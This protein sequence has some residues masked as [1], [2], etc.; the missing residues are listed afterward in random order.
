MS[1]WRFEN[2]IPQVGKTTF[3]APSAVVWGDV[4]IGE[5]C[6]VGHGAVIRGDYG[7]IVIGDGC[8]IQDLVMIHARPDDVVRIGNNA[9][10]GH[11]ALLHNCTI[12]DNAVV[13]MGAIVSDFAILKDWAV[14]AEGA[15]AKNGSVLESGQIAIG[16][17]AAV[18]GSIHDKPKAKEELERFK[19]K[20]QEMA[21]RHLADNAFEEIVN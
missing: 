6:Y 10:I 13:G 14:L 12:E 3:V 11:R 4:T 5:G 9:T 16:I 17:P 1:I 8:S 7:K 21:R 19:L 18:I 2:K 15:L 20:Y